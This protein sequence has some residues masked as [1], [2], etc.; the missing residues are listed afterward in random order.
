[1][2]DI[3]MTGGRVVEPSQDIDAAILQAEAR[4]DPDRRRIPRLRLTIP[5]ERTLPSAFEDSRALGASCPRRMLFANKLPQI[6]MCAPQ[7][8]LNIALFRAN[9]S[10]TPHVY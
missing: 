3:A 6:R 8:R 7:S 10:H 9:R 2:C 1:M 4:N 5:D